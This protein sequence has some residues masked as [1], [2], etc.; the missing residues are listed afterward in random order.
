MSIIINDLKPGDFVFVD[1]EWGPDRCHFEGE[2]I[3]RQKGYGALVIGP[4]NLLT[5]LGHK[6]NGKYNFEYYN[7]S[8]YLIQQCYIYYCF[9]R[10]V[11][12]KL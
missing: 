12:K 10:E 4:P 8:K 9:G 5:E 7:K 1:G 2:F 11:I 3:E 6:H